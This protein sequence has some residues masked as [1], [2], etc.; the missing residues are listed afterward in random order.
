MRTGKQAGGRSIA[1]PYGLDG[2]PVTAD[3]VRRIFAEFC[4]PYRRPALSEIAAALNVDQVPTQRGCRWH[5]STVR[6]IL[7]NSAYVPDVIDVATFEQAQQRLQ[8][9]RSGPPR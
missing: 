6:Y 4:E 5:A 3:I 8:R 7:Q 1:I 9:L 2:D